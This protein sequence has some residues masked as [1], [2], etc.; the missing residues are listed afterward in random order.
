MLDEFLAKQHFLI[1]LDKG[2]S[3]AL[4]KLYS[5]LHIIILFKQ[6]KIYCKLDT[7]PVNSGK[8]N[9]QIEVKENMKSDLVEEHS[10]WWIC[11][12]V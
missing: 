6:W 7:K 11:I 8:T 3:R 9:Y 2:F 10:V 1:F 12:E 5:E 4:W